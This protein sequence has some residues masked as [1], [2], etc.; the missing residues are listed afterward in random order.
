MRI[1]ETLRT[2][3]SKH[4]SIVEWYLDN[5]D[6]V[7]RTARAGQYGLVTS[8][9]TE[10]NRDL[11]AAVRRA[12]ELDLPVTAF[13]RKRSFL[14]KLKKKGKNSDLQLSKTQDYKVEIEIKRTC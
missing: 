1:L 4:I 2:T 9:Y 14:N 13:S 5:V 8:M 10:S 6:S 3:K 11:V 7:G 12:G